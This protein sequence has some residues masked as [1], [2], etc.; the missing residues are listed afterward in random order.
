MI[1][2]EL[3]SK[4]RTGDTP[5]HFHRRKRML[6]TQVIAR[7][8]DDPQV[9]SAMEL[10][11]R[12]RFVE[13]NLESS[14]YDDTPLP[15]REGQTISQPFIVAYMTA[16]LRLRGNER[17]LEVG[18]GSGYQTAVLAELAG[19][20]Y[21]LEINHN[22]TLEAA[23]RF[24]KQGYKNI[25]VMCGDGYDGWPERAP[26]DGIVVTAAP[27]HVPRTLVQQLRVG[28]KM[29]IPVGGSEQELLLITRLSDGSYHR[30]PRIPVRFV[31]MIRHAEN[32]N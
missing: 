6:R 18:T 14:A 2:F 4:L 8:V 29:V 19:Q 9:L 25:E 17:L 3:D 23:L 30:E 20:V 16:A 15:I 26:F 13:E 10:V 28:A 11:P 32:K 24:K 1:E 5:A 21:T 31:P 27:D 7:G 12:H 22:L